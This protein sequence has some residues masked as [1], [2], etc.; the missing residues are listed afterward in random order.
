MKLI[1]FY[2]PIFNPIIELIEKEAKL[3]GWANHEG[4]RVIAQAK[5]GVKISKFEGRWSRIK[6]EDETKYAWMLLKL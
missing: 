3:A 5:F 4:M 2:E 6:V 1:K